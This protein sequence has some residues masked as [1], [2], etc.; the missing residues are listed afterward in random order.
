M[1][2]GVVDLIYQ[3]YFPENAKILMIH[4]GG[5]QGVEGMN[6]YLEQKKMKKIDFNE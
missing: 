2:F 5:L 4:T 3:G 6:R 1:V